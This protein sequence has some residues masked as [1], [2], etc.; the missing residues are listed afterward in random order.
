[1]T[2]T[3]LPYLLYLLTSYVGAIATLEPLGGSS[4]YK[5]PERRKYVYLKRKP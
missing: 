3:V 4:L 5:C 2:M 1:M